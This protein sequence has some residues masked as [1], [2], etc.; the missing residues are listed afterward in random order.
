V[1]D[2]PVRRLEQVTAHA[3]IRHEHAH[4]QEHRDDAEGVVSHRPHRR[5]ADQLE[6]RRSADQ[7]AEAGN[8]DQ[9]HR[10]ADRHAQQH[11]REQRDEPKDGNGVGAH[12]VSFTRPV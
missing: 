5:L 8:A 6:R 2:E 10:H 12:A 7:V 11:Q 9:A 1:T 4:Q 3:G